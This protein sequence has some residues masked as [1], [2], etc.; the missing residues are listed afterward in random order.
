KA[1]AA[2][3]DDESLG[4]GAADVVLVGERLA[5]VPGALTA[6]HRLARHTG[7]RLAWVPRRAGDRPAVEAGCLPGL[8][9]GGR[10]VADASARAD[11][12]AAW[13][14][15]SLP[16]EPGRDAAAIWAAA[17][18]GELAGLVVGGVELDDLPDRD[19]A[20]AALDAA[21]F[22]VSLEV[23]ESDVTARADVVLPVAPPVEKSGTFVT[24]EGRRRPF[25]TVIDQPNSLPDARVLAGMAEEMGRPLGFRTTAQVHTDVLDVGL[26]DGDRAAAPLV[27]PGHAPKVAAGQAVLSTWRQLVDDGRGQDGDDA[28]RATARRSVARL[29]ATTIAG[30]GLAEGDEVVLRTD[31]G[32]VALPVEA[33]DL[34][35]GVV[36]APANSG[37]LSLLQVLG[38]RSGDT[39][40]LEVATTEVSA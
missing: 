31:R 18:A 33:A 12:A 2:L 1:L 6:A 24:W 25:G 14:V 9:P 30:L 35:D 16:A 21:E 15:D 19:V 5:T 36:W 38:A 17:A 26:W 40:S 32:A 39:V 27:E 8:L 22:V 37:G 13:G 28:Y 3:A 11:L 29:S 23:R 10:P 7:A 34:A 4:L 20:L